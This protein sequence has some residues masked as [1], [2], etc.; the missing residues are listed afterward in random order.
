MQVDKGVK[1]ELL[2]ILKE[3]K[4][5]CDRQSLAQELRIDERSIRKCIRE[6]RREGYP[7]ISTSREKG[8]RIA[9]SISDAMYCIK[10]MRNREKDIKETADC[11]EAKCYDM[12][13]S[14]QIEYKEGE[15]HDYIHR[16]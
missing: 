14:G 7:I 13:L 15:E 9:K 5:N 10:E 12:V 4:G 1:I 8:Y 16:H 2:D 3:R 6:L 11:M